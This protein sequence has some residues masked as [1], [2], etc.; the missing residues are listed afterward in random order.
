MA[1]AFNL[2]ESMYLIKDKNLIRVSEKK[3]RLINTEQISGYDLKLICYY[4]GG[5][6]IDVDK[7]DQI[8]GNR[9]L[10]FGFKGWS[11][12]NQKFEWYCW[13]CH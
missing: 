6:L 2:L 4:C 11:E 10:K 1:I 12:I 9:I 7:I 5:K 13:N 8:T 3:E